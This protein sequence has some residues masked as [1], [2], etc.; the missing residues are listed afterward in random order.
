LSAA[1]FQQ[2]SHAHFRDFLVLHSLCELPSDYFLDRFS[3]RLL[4][5]SFFL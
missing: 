1:C 4:I 5:N 2:R 3:L